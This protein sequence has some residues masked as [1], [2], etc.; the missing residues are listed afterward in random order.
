M[1]KELIFEKVGEFNGLN[2]PESITN[3]DELGADMALDSLD[4]VEV[5]ME[6]EKRTGR[7]IPDEVLDVKPYYELTVGELTNML[8]NYLKDYER[9]ELLEIVREEIFEKMHKFNYINNIEVIDDVREDSNLSSDLAMD[10]FDLLE[11]LIGIEEKMDIRISD[12]V[13]GDKSVDELT[14]GIFVD[15][16]YDWLE[17]K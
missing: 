6:M 10:P 17:S 16:L 14:V 12:D 5:V 3:N 15:M 13:F 7:C 8:Y 11:V 9:D 2:H 4:F 1:I